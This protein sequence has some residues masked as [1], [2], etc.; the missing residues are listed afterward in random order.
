MLSQTKNE[1]AKLHRQRLFIE[2]SEL[3]GKVSESLNVWDEEEE[4]GL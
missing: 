4:D 3:Y 1:S 2:R